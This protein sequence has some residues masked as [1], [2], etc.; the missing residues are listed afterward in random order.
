[1]RPEGT[2]NILRRLPGAPWTAWLLA[3]LWLALIVALLW[4]PG[5]EDLI[6]RTHRAAGGTELTDAL[7]HVALFGV[8]VVLLAAARAQHTTTE[9]AVRWAV[10][11][12]AALGLVIEVGQIGVPERGF[13][14][15]DLAAN[16][17]GPVLLWV[18]W[19]WRAARRW[20][21]HA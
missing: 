8:L 21:T 3:A 16:W 12:A 1:M 5:D 9:H 17:T 7:G 18:A 19:R 13:A 14:L 2:R 4:T 20:P 10:R 11:V 6:D 15:Y